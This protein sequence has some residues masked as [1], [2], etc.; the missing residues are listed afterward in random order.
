MN[1]NKKL[2]VLAGV[3]GWG[4]LAA[5][6]VFAC[7]EYDQALNRLFEQHLACRQSKSANARW[8]KW[9][10]G[11]KSARWAPR[12]GA[13]SRRRPPTLSLRSSPHE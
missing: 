7:P 4:S 13:I 9:S 8:S 10:C 12:A 3:K 1:P 6:T 11:H 5:A 2:Y